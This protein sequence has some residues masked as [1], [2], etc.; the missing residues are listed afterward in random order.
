MLDEFGDHLLKLADEL[1][2]IVAV[3]FNFAKA[4]FPDTCEL[5][6]LEQL[7]ADEADELDARGCGYEIFLTL[8]T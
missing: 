6:A 2:G 3:G 8:V 4:F 5:G 1:L 7:F